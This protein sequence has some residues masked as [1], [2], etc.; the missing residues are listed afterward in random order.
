MS[1]S[2]T[3]NPKQEVRQPSVQLP[4]KLHPSF[5]LP[6]SLP[7][8]ANPSLQLVQQL[9]VE[10][11]PSVSNFIDGLPEFGSLS[12]SRSTQLFGLD[13]LQDAN[14]ASG[15]EAPTALCPAWP[16]FK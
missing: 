3:L 9:P 1:P 13:F 15:A 4:I 5:Q 10:I 16:G 6:L 14:I 11:D 8:K 7:M 2:A 12:P